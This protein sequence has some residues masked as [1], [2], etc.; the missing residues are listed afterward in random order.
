MSK[1]RFFH[2]S[3][4]LLNDD[5]KQLLS[6]NNLLIHKDFMFYILSHIH[7][8]QLFQNNKSMIEYMNNNTI[9]NSKSISCHNTRDISCEFELKTKEHQKKY[10]LKMKKLREKLGIPIS[11]KTLREIYYSKSGGSSKQHL[12]LNRIINFMINNQLLEVTQEKFYKPETNTF[13]SRKFKIG[14]KYMSN[15][16]SYE[17]L[18]E[19]LK[20]RLTLHSEQEFK[21]LPEYLQRLGDIC[22]NKFPFDKKKAYKIAEQYEKDYSEHIESCANSTTFV[23]GTNVNRIYTKYTLLPSKLRGAIK[24]ADSTNLWEIDI[25]NCQP[26]LLNKWVKDTEDGKLWKMLT[27]TGSLY[28]HFVTETMDRNTVKK[29]MFQFMFGKLKYGKSKM[30][31]IIKKEFPEVFRVMQYLDNISLTGKRAYLLQN[32]EADIMLK[33][34]AV[35]CMDLNIDILTIH[36]SL[37]FDKKYK[38]II[39]SIIE[40]EVEKHIGYKPTLKS[41]KL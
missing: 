31:P 26:F 12:E 35:K 20:K 6:N 29:E 36:D 11:I 23:K 4:N 9:H 25:T 38:S 40:E 39:T 2:I 21:E 19:R 5:F 37:I 7:F 16:K 14:D 41:K 28:E 3:S 8:I 13:T 17:C 1:A 32:L 34:V 24:H 10:K 18:D 15:I 30:L 27:S 33:N 22:N